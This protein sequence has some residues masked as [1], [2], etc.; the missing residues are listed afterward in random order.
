MI[1]LIIDSGV[2]ETL[3]FSCFNTTQDR[4]TFNALSPTTTNNSDVALGTTWSLG[5]VEAELCLEKNKGIGEL[6]STAFIARD[7]MKIVDA[8]GED[9]LLRYYGQ[10]ELSWTPL[11][12]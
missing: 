7:M 6:M 8:L 12:G 11:L 1:M 2:G 10:L 3:P 5:G 9:G 4:T